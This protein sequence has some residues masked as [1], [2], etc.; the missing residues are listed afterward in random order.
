ME[1]SEKDKKNYK[2]FADLIFNSL[3]AFLDEQKFN[4]DV[5]MFIGKLEKTL[6]D[7][8]FEE[9][10][11]NDSDVISC[12]VIGAYRFNKGIEI[13]CIVV[14]DF[15]DWFKLSTFQSQK[16]IL[17]NVIAKLSTIKVLAK[18]PEMPF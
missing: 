13:P 15:L 18:E 11:Q 5:E 7:N 4:Y 3:T 8:L 9:I 12:I 2:A 1:I 6:R 16:L 14:K 17:T 10:I